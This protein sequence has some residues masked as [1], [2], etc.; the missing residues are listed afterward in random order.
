VRQQRDREYRHRE[1]PRSTLA[2][3]KAPG[4]HDHRNTRDRRQGRGGF[5]DLEREDREHQVQ[6]AAQWPHG[7]HRDVEQAI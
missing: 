3:T 6:V 2:A 4:E 5:G 1:E 7:R